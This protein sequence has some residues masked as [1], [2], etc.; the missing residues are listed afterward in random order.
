M[1]SASIPVLSSPRLMLRPVSMA[2]HAPLLAI[3]QDADVTRYLHEGP[4]PSAEE[5]NNRLTRAIGQWELRG[6]GM[7][8]VEDTSG[9]VGR[10]GVFTLRILLT[11]CSS[12]FFPGVVGARD[13]PRRRCPSFWSGCAP[14][15][16]QNNFWPILIRAIGGRYALPQSSGRLA[17]ARLTEPEPAWNSGSFQQGAEPGET[18]PRFDRRA[19]RALS[20]TSCFP[21]QPS[22][23]VGRREVAGRVAVHSQPRHH[24][25]RPQIVRRG[26]GDHRIQPD[27]V[28]GIG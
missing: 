24:S 5:L 17:R 2:D 15:T 25:L 6:Y 18:L 16:E 8:V 28:K 23:A 19:P 21:N 13:T 9:I 20:V 14:P 1:Q 12:T 27:A 10:M 3:A 7:M 4:E 22:P 26:I 11:R